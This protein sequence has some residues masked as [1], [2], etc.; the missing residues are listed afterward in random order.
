MN[1][2]VFVSDATWPR[3]SGSK[4]PVRHWLP[5]NWTPGISTVPQ[6]VI[7][8]VQRTGRSARTWY[9]LGLG[10]GVVLLLGGCETVERVQPDLP[11]V[12]QR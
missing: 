3:E 5:W 7:A 9:R 4:R 8:F 10:I 6:R 1:A 11:G 12:G 2:E